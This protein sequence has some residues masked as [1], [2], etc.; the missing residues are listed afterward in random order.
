MHLASSINNI[1]HLAPPACSGCCRSSGADELEPAL[2]VDPGGGGGVD[3]PRPPCVLVLCAQ[4]LG[5]VLIREKTTL[6]A[7]TCLIINVLPLNASRQGLV[8][9]VGS[10]L[11]PLV[12]D[13]A[14]PR[15]SWVETAALP[16]NVE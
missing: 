6:F 4:I 7:C 15:W 8:K 16:G 5:R 12:D 13:E 11:N 3:P 14:S 9:P 1:P 10:D 2:R